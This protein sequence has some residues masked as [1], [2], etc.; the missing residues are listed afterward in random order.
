MD[1][2]GFKFLNKSFVVYNKNKMR[3]C[4]QEILNKIRGKL[5]RLSQ[6]R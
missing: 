2:N 5:E 6:T 3:C 4:E 1:R